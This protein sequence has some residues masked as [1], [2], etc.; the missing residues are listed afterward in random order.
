MEMW[1]RPDRI[2]YFS[3]RVVNN[4]CSLCISKCM[5]LVDT[6]N[7]N[8]EGFQKSLVTLDHPARYTMYRG[9]AVL[10]GK[11][12]MMCLSLVALLLTLLRTLRT[13]VMLACCENSCDS[14]RKGLC[15]RRIAQLLAEGSVELRLEAGLF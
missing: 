8:A 5:S 10:T 9:A 13:C 14:A 1:K 12:S 3:T 7:A 15:G 11:W 6:Y 4:V 2:E